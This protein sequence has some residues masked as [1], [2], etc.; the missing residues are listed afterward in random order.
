MQLLD[1]TCVLTALSVRS[2]EILKACDL[3][4]DGLGNMQPTKRSRMLP[5]LCRCSKPTWKLAWPA[6][7]DGRSPSP[8]VDRVGA[9]RCLR[10]VPTLFGTAE[11]YMKIVQQQA[12]AQGT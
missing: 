7:Y 10:P 8:S 5:R 1:C 2:L 3:T 4:G 6:M 12:T 11:E 9:S